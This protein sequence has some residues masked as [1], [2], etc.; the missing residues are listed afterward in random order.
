[1]P[2]QGITLWRSKRGGK[3]RGF[4]RA[5]WREGGRRITWDTRTLDQGEALAKAAAEVSRRGSVPVHRPL[6]VPAQ[7]PPV[8]PDG[9]APPSSAAPVAADAPA[10]VRKPIGEALTRALGAPAAA[11]SSPPVTDEEGKRKARKL[12]EVFGKAMGYLTE[13]SLKR[14]VRFAGREPEDMDDDELELVREGWEEKG[15]DWFGRTNIGPWGKIALGSA[16]A[17]VGMYMGGKPL[18]KPKK[19]LPPVP[20]GG[21]NVRPEPEGGGGSG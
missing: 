15:A 5:S 10:A 8:H 9:I 19:E 14:A 20:A 21:A 2:N 11:A 6:E 13:G 12:Y 3:P 16:V 1:M 4:I 17:G 7:A 18:P